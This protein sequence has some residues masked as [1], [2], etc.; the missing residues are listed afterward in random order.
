[1]EETLPFTIQLYF[2]PME[3]TIL[4]NSEG[5]FICEAE[6]NPPAHI[7]WS[8]IDLPWPQSAV[9][10]GA[11]LRLKEMTPDL[12]GLY[13]CEASNQHGSKQQQLCVYVAV[14]SGNCTACW[15]L[16]SLLFILSVAAVAAAGYLYKSGTIQWSGDR[17]LVPTI[18]LPPEEEQVL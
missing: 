5:S 8:R 16:F 13:Q 6:A 7:T 10:E 3:V 4:E 15:V 11:V 9:R 2:P 17:Q 14:A 12:N 1:M 18:S